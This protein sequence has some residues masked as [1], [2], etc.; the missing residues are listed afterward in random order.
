MTPEAQAAPA[1]YIERDMPEA[2]EVEL[3]GGRAMVFSTRSPRKATPNEDAIAVIPTGEKSGVLVIADGMGGMPG[4]RQA[5]ALAVREVARAVEA[6]AREGRELRSSILDAFERANR[7]VLEIGNGGTTLAVA[8]IDAGRMRSYHVGDSVVLVTGQRGRL[9]LETIA[10]SPVGYALESGL[11]DAEAAMV[12]EDRHL[13]TN[14]VGSP[15]MRIDVG[16][17]LTLA[18][19]DTVLLASDGLTDNLYA[20]EI[21]EIVRK[22]RLERAAEVLRD[23]CVERMNGDTPEHPSKPD[24][25]SFIVFR[26]G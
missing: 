20:S 13:I 1:L 19:R 5:S 17:A 12:H 21:V 2:A 4:G 9:K 15:E 3:A 6:G 14:A 23:G 7:K 16:P 24:D 22:G 10:H 25:L 8:E 11:L 18:R 26:A